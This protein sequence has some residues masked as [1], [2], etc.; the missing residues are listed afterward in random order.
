MLGLLFGRVAAAPQPK[1]GR[2]WWHCKNETL[3]ETLKAERSL[4]GIC[5]SRSCG[6]PSLLR[7]VPLPCNEMNTDTCTSHVEST[8]S[9]KL[10]ACRLTTNREACTL[11]LRC[12]PTSKTIRIQE[13]ATCSNETL[14]ATL[15]AESSL[16]GICAGRTCS[17]L[18]ADGS[19]MSCERLGVADCE[20]HVDKSSLKLH[21]CQLTFDRQGCQLG[22]RCKLIGAA[23]GPAG[24]PPPSHRGVS[25]RRSR[26]SNDTL[27]EILEAESSLNGICARRF[28]TPPSHT[29]A[30]VSCAHVD[31]VGCTQYVATKS[32]KLY[33]CQLTEDQ[34]GCEL[35]DRCKKTQS[36]VAKKAKL[37]CS[38][39]TINATLKE[40]E[41]LDGICA[42]RLCASP[43]AEGD[44]MRCEQLSIGVCTRHV[45]KLASKLHACSVTEDGRRCELGD[46][47]N[48]IA[49]QAAIKARRESLGMNVCTNETL[50]GTLGESVGSLNGICSGRTCAPA[51]VQGASTRCD[52]LGAAE[53]ERYVD[54][55]NF[56]MH[57]C[58]VAADGGSCELGERCKLT[59]GQI[60]RKV[61]W[62]ER[63][64]CSNETV[65]STL[66]EELSLD[67]IC[68]GRTCASASAD[69]GPKQ[70]EQ[71]SSTECTRHLEKRAL[72][73]HQ[74]QL[75]QDGKSCELGD[76][77]NALAR[78]AA[79]SARREAK[80]TCS[81]DTLSDTLE[82]EFALESICGIRTCAPP[83]SDGTPKSCEQLSTS[84]CLNYV[85][86]KALKLFACQLTADKKACELGERCK[87][88][89]RGLELQAKATC[90]NSTLNETLGGDSSLDGICSSRTCTPASADGTPMPCERVSPASCRRHV[91]TKSYKLHACE[92]TADK[93]ACE[94]GERCKVISR[95]VAGA[96]LRDEL[97]GQK[98]KWIKSAADCSRCIAFLHL[99][100]SAGTTLIRVLEQPKPRTICGGI[101]YCDWRQ[102]RSTRCNASG[103]SSALGSSGLR[104]PSAP[105]L[106]PPAAPP[107]SSS[108]TIEENCDEVE[109]GDAQDISAAPNVSSCCMRTV[110]Q[111]THSAGYWRRLWDAQRRDFEH[112]RLY[113]GG[114]TGAM[115]WAGSHVRSRCIF[116]TLL[117]EP[118]S[119]LA[120]I[121]LY[122]KYGVH[123][124]TDGIPAWMPVAHGG[125]VLCGGMQNASLLTWARSIGNQL[126]RQLAIQPETFA[127]LR[128]DQAM[129]AE[130]SEE[131]LTKTV[132]RIFGPHEKGT[133]K[134][135]QKVLEKVEHELRTGVMPH[136]VGVF[137][138]LERT[139]LLL[140][141]VAPL[142]GGRRWLR[143]ARR[144]AYTHSSRQW[145]LEKRRLLRAEA[146]S[147]RAELTADVQLYRAGLDRFEKL[148]STSGVLSMERYGPPATTQKTDAAWQDRVV[149]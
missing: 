72:K 87:P 17:P 134:L 93:K 34:Q 86:K 41:S 140:D 65:N 33:A 92:L 137:E 129:E 4:D 50:N 75:T 73:L 29:G 1:R 38:N 68:A 128:G 78:Q 37:T 51:S 117:R 24:P 133:T 90:S 127:M 9:G 13:R 79:V 74:C 125:D 56:K 112:A 54:R 67:G 76:R 98:K 114:Y 26:C 14:T 149:G 64:T 102:Y 105:P 104:L 101:Y 16:D 7:D 84:E 27:Q 111:D 116:V 109:C 82:A 77:C 22:G 138:Q 25:V 91:E 120:S 70:C 80:A 136:V 142:N 139:L 69:G 36:A 58:V 21:A 94:L 143:A 23:A 141:K 60:A 110:R 42:G 47:C 18:S 15:E 95:K 12:K 113:Y 43:T 130:A 147:V 100:K 103:S 85:D 52:Q 71:L 122:C 89:A 20:R 135:G 28:C 35:G 46:R 19:S 8:R 44:A 11:G 62:E 32:R 99:H 45:E 66:A 81:N 126:F 146:D 131:D 48:L 49:R 121:A 96:S 61:R 108:A 39:T 88:T 2:G 5:G 10:H 119:R 53:C 132:R 59:A 6:P 145:S 30:P 57:A 31:T 123:E 144:K 118:V 148:C 55:R 83:S 107:W 106:P 40:E 3:Y 115:S 124:G 97:R 63:A